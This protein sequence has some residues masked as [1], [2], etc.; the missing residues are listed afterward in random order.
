M[1]VLSFPE[2][3][4]DPE[5]E[6]PQNPEPQL[7]I[8][9]A[10][11]YKAPTAG[12]ALA[13]DSRPGLLRNNLFVE[14]SSMDV[15]PDPAEL[16]SSCLRTQL[17]PLLPLP[18]SLS[19]LEERIFSLA[20]T[21]LFH[22]HTSQVPNALLP[23]G[24][25]F[26]TV[27]SLMPP[28]QETLGCT[29]RHTVRVGCYW[30]LAGRER[31]RLPNMPQFDP[32]ADPVPSAPGVEALDRKQQLNWEEPSLPNRVACPQA[33]SLTSCPSEHPLRA[34]FLNRPSHTANMRQ[35]IGLSGH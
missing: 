30:H 31:A 14:R 8:C 28:D 17:F 4:S 22:L 16:A 13:H 10:N 2:P 21:A 5:A 23:V 20:Q 35:L 26:I 25:L 33:P 3:E 11:A 15:P 27:T 9:S 6:L 29:W 18:G 24:F 34:P 7:S 1:P 12:W 19:S 32:K